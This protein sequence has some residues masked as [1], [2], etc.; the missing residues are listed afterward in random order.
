[1]DRQTNQPRQP[2]GAACAEVPKKPSSRSQDKSEILQESRYRTG[3]NSTCWSLPLEHLAGQKKQQH[4][5]CCRF[6]SDK[7]GSDTMILFSARRRRSRSDFRMH[8]SLVSPWRHLLFSR[9]V[10]LLAGPGTRVSGQRAILKLSFRGLHCL[11]PV[12][13]HDHFGS[14]LFSSAF[15]DYVLCEHEP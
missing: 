13:R 10:F 11:R 2:S 14:L 15:G 4:R 5:R 7:Q 1:M 3:V 8:S 6:A 12:F 9:S